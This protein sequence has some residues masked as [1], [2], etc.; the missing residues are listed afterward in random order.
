M[1]LLNS[2]LTGAWLSCLTLDGNFSRIVVSAIT[3]PIHAQVSLLISC[4]IS[5]TQ[6]LKGGCTLDTSETRWWVGSTLKTAKVCP[7]TLDLCWRPWALITDLEETFCHHRPQHRD[8]LSI[9]EKSYIHCQNTS[10]ALWTR[11]LKDI[12]K[13]WKLAIVLW[14][15]AMERRI[16]LLRN[17]ER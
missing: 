4:L 14:D 2:V 11:A 8:N 10:L 5:T 17:T 7:A 12:C 15:G 6:Q 16:I 3:E 1:L 13:I 9:R